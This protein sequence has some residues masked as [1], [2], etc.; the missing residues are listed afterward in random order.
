M[1]GRQVY[2]ITDWRRVGITARKGE[3]PALRRMIK[4]RD[5]YRCTKCGRAGKLQ[6]HH[7]KHL[8]DGGDDHPDNL[9]A[10][11]IDCHLSIHSTKTPE[12]NDWKRAVKELG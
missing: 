7:I 1:L 4:E 5:G 6:V 11:C 12:Q 9:T 2:A 3:W 10:L 8:K